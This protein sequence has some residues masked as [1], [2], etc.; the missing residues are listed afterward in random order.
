[1]FVFATSNALTNTHSKQTA[2]HNHMQANQ[3]AA[4]RLPAF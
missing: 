3:I 2:A 1:L 4:V